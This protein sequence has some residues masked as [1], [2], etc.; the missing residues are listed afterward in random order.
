M[1]IYEILE[2]LN[3][4]NGKKYKESVLRKHADN[5]LFQKVLKMTYDSVKFTYGISMKNV[6]IPTEEADSFRTLEQCLEILEKHFVT[7][8]FTGNAAIDMLEH[9]FQTLAD[10]GDRDVLRK[11]INRDLRINVGTTMI[12]K[13]FPGLITK[14]VYMRCGTGTKKALAKINVKGAFAQLK[15]DGTYREFRVDSGTVKCRSRSAEEYEYP[16]INEILLQ[17]VDGVYMGELTVYRDGVLLPRGEGNGLLKKNEFPADCKVV[18]DCWDVVSLEDY[19]ACAK[20]KKARGKE[21]YSERFERLISLFPDHTAD[22]TENCVRVIEYV[23]V[24]SIKEAME[25][26]VERMKHGLEGSVLKDKDALFRD[27]TSAEQ[28]KL[29][30]VIEG[31]FEVTG[32]IEGK[33]GTE[34]EATFGSM[35]F[36]SK[37]G[38][39]QGSVSGFSDE[40]LE[41]YNARREETIG[42]IINLEFNDITRARDSETWALSHPRFIEERTDKTEADTFERTLEAKEMAMNMEELV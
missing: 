38:M 33:P 34:R 35:K 41:Y 32:F 5:E 17:A 9:M 18:F 24:D 21:K 26:T 16:E 2:E 37:C 13:V 28:L 4:E 12:N 30:L 39:I 20:N 14:A 36:K 40:Q 22:P 1:T 31:D 42:A 3:L 7:R 27:G 10:E 11:V 15:A 6:N 29:K 23:I 8:N 25:F 19:D